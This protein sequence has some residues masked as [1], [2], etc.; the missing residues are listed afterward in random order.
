MA[1]R[2]RRTRQSADPGSVDVRATTIKVIRADDS[3]SRQLEV[4]DEFAVSMFDSLIIPPPYALADLHR[5]S[6]H[7]A[8]LRPCIEAYVVNTVQTGWEIEP[9]VRGKHGNEGEI[10]E[11]N[12]FV[13]NANSD[14]SLSA[15]LSLVID[16]RETYGFGFMEGIRDASN[17][18]SLIRYA[19]AIITRLCPKGEVPILVEYTIQR[20]RRVTH[21]KEFK[22]FR[23]FLQIV[24]G[25]QVFFKEWGDPRRMNRVTGKYED[26]EGY[27]GGEDA[28]ELYH[29]KLKSE[30][31][32]G[33]PRWITQLPSIIGSREA[34][35]VNMNYFKDN[36]VPPIML[37][38]SGGRLTQHSFQQLSHQLA[39]DGIGKDRQNRIMLV[40]ATGDSDSLDGKG[41]PVQLRVEKLTDSRQSD[42][43]FDAYDKNNMAK[44]RMAWRLPGIV[45]G[46]GSDLNYANAQVSIF[47]ADSQVFGPARVEI[48]EVLNKQL[49]F[50]RH[51]LDIKTVKLASRV[52]T[53]SSPETMIKTL[54][55]LNVM[56]AV[57][58][59]AAQANANKFLQLEL[60]A[61]PEKGEEGYQEWMDMPLQMTMKTASTTHPEQAAKTAGIKELEED[62]DV[63]FHQ[64][65]KGAEGEAM[66]R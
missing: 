34:E 6:T 37:T 39:T 48:E 45:L 58:P 52:P 14:E 41:T 28:T 9:V 8:A 11:L 50:P 23:R 54:T 33:I 36:T 64:P 12:S 62:G 1:P 60:P 53:I 61:Y 27:T 40:E 24:G 25:Q 44:I 30:E 56:G 22:K 43:L 57:T 65:E 29:F 31:P 32:Y 7:S 35:E 59:R 42:S 3:T 4:Q 10:A 20:G 15:V 18:L 38:V 46:A 63:G 5:I 17:A 26:E 19:P 66:E 55:A 21:V 13:E 49:V 51:G 16:D 47:T 2:I